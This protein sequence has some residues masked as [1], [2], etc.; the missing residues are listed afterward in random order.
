MGLL[1]RDPVSAPA[2]PVWLSCS[3]GVGG[4]ALGAGWGP[5]FLS[6]GP[7]RG[8]AWASSQHGVW[9]P[10]RLFQGALSWDP[11]AGA[12][13]LYRL[14]LVMW[15][16]NLPPLP[17]HGRGHRHHVLM[18]TKEFVA[19]LELPHLKNVFQYFVWLLI[20]ICRFCVALYT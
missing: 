15:S 17:I 3:T 6:R 20:H 14:P 11:E 5:V 9:F 12:Q 16:W 2:P 10:E 18:G 1:G 7:P 4:V 19:V 8:T 13:G